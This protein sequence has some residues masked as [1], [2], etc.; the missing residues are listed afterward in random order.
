MTTCLDAINDNLAAIKDSLDAITQPFPWVNFTPAFAQGTSLTLTTVYY[1]YYREDRG[2]GIAELNVLF[3]SAGTASNALALTNWPM[4]VYGAPSAAP[5]ILGSWALNR[6]GSN[7]VGCVILQ[8][9][10]TVNFL[11]GVP[12]GQFGAN[13][14]VT[15]ASGDNL[16]LSTI[17]RLYA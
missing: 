6:S 13:P 10:N 7:Y 1:A 8:P 11:A 4:T 2:V 14:A 3:G 16:R 9:D 15:I 17:Q 12:G 5:H